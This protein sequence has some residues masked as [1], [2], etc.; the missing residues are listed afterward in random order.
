MGSGSS[1]PSGGV[2]YQGLYYFVALP[3]NSAPGNFFYKYDGTN[4]SLVST[5]KVPSTLPAVFNGAM[6]FGSTKFDGTNFTTLSGTLPTS[7][8]S[9]KIFNGQLYFSGTD[10]TH[11][12]ELWKCDGI[13]MTRVTDINPGTAS[14]NPGILT[15]FNNALYFIATDTTGNGLWKFDGTNATRAGTMQLNGFNGFTVL[16]GYIYVGA[17]TNG[18][19]FEPWRY[20]GTNFSLVAQISAAHASSSPVFWTNYHNA[21]Y[22]VAND[23]VN[24]N[25]LWNFDGTNANRLTS[26]GTQGGLYAFVFND[27]LY[28]TAADRGTDYELW[29]YDGTNV[30]EVADIA[31]GGTGSLPMPLSAYQNSFYFQA[32]DGTHGTELWRLDALSDDFRMISLTPQGDDVL[33]TVL[34]PGGWTNVIQAA[35]TPNVA[36]NFADISGSIIATNTASL[37]TTTYLDPGGNLNHTSH[38]YR[39]RLGP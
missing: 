4:A 32:N 13:N 35:D 16:N 1:S 38:Y 18:T 33:L 17:T 12:S 39:L 29:K 28:F 9:M 21:V 10:S 34:S 6:Y 37:A 14:S 20:D 26:F 25:Q 27:T 8:G 11:G 30:S 24:S 36:A 5:T 22:F 3:S 19:D 31:P 23:G 7:I 15:L 2:V